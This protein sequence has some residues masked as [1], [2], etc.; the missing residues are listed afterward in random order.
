MKKMN[1]QDFKTCEYNRRKIII[2]C[3]EASTKQ[4]ARKSEEACK[5]IKK[6][7]HLST[8]A[9]FGAHVPLGEIPHQVAIGYEVDKTKIS[10]D[11]GGSLISKEWILTAGK[12]NCKILT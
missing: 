7:K 2:C 1:L 8:R 10:Y 11:C 3:K 6:T 4:E 5:M 9:I 12:K